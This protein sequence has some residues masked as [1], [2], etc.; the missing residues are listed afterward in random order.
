MKIHA[1]CG[2]E[3]LIDEEDFDLVGRYKWAISHTGKNYYAITTLSNGQ[4]MHRM[5]MKAKDGQIIDHKNGNGLDNR[6]ENLRFCTNT[7]NSRNQGL[8]KRNKTGFKGVSWSKT[9]KGFMAQISCDRKVKMLG[10]FDCPFKAARAY[11]AAALELHGEFANINF[12]K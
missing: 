5:I 3:I 9:R 7:E 2:T 1:I 12:K 6:R 10:V 4:R 8:T 11:D